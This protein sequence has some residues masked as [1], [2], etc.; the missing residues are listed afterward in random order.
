[1]RV[2][3]FRPYRNYSGL[4]VF[5]GKDKYEAVQICY[6]DTDIENGKPIEFYPAKVYLYKHGTGDT[7]IERLQEFIA[8]AQLAI[9][10]ATAGDTAHDFWSSETELAWVEARIAVNKIMKG[11]E[12]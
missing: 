8:A 12:K 10:L 9:E 1:M 6:M 11:G 2:E 7:S 4:K 3:L 5:P